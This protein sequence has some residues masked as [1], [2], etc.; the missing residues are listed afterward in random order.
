MPARAAKRRRHAKPGQGELDHHRRGRREHRHQA[1]TRAV[2]DGIGDDER[3]IRPGNEH[4]HDNGGYKG[5]IER[6][7]NPCFDLYSSDVHNDIVGLSLSANLFL[8]DR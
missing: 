4:Q 1:V 8:S 6:H 7:G 5:E 2:S 3:H